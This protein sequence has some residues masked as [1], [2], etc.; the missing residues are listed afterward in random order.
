MFIHLHIL[1]YHMFID[2]LNSTL[3]VRT[4]ASVAAAHREHCTEAARYIYTCINQPL[5][6]LALRSRKTLCNTWQTILLENICF[7]MVHAIAAEC[8]SPIVASLSFLMRTSALRFE[9]HIGARWSLRLTLSVTEHSTPLQNCVCAL[10]VWRYNYRYY[11][12][13]KSL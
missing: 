2:R 1:F 13:P 9:V 5:P 7:M 4:I 6:F 11:Y 12:L 10:L 8:T 3:Y